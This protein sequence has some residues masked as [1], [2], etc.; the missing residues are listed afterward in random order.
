MPVARDHGRVQPAM[1]PSD[2]EVAHTEAPSPRDCED[3]VA[4]RHQSHESAIPLVRGYPATSWDEST[5]PGVQ[6]TTRAVRGQR[7][8]E[9]RSSSNAVRCRLESSSTQR[10]GA[11]QQSRHSILRPYLLDWGCRW[12]IA[13][14]LLAIAVNFASSN[15]NP[16]GQLEKYSTWCGDDVCEARIEKFGWCPS[17]C[18]CGDGVCDDSEAVAASCPQDCLSHVDIAKQPSNTSQASVAFYDQ[19]VIRISSPTQSDAYTPGKLIS[20]VLWESS[21]LTLALFDRAGTVTATLYH[22]IDDITGT[23]KLNVPV[24]GVR[25]LFWHHCSM[26]C[27]TFPSLLAPPF[28]ALLYFL[29]TVPA[30]EAY[31]SGCCS[32]VCLDTGRCLGAA[33]VRASRISS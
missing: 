2:A 18:F 13:L 32:R 16:Q 6:I 12:R 26:F 31:V 29:P 4:A 27:S 20:F 9:Q 8:H 15:S 11:A 24:E 25:P 3:A 19:P 22:I 28:H 1:S 30:A 23:K 5:S 7:N 14:M 21:M 33:G 17:D 10:R